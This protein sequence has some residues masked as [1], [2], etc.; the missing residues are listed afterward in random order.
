MSYLNFV[1]VLAG[2]LL[3]AVAQLFL[4]SGTNAL[5][6]LQILLESEGLISAL[7]KIIFQPWIFGGLICYVFSVTIWIVALSRIPVSVAYPML[8]IGYV[9][10]AVAAWYLFGEILSAQKIFGIGI[11]II[12]VYIISKSF[13][14]K[15]YHS[16]RWR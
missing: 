7:L 5:G 4:K 1:L 11:I 14:K 2:V 3:N 6:S 12:G 8:S 15:T 10:N 16:R 9:V 13:I